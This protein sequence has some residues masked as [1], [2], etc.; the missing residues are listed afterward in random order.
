[1]LHYHCE[2]HSERERLDRVL[3]GSTTDCPLLSI[4]VK[5][6]ARESALKKS[7]ITARVVTLTRAA[8]SGF[9]ADR[10]YS[11]S[12]HQ[13]APSFSTDSPSETEKLLLDF[14][15]Q[16]RLGGEFTYRYASL[17]QPRL[18]LIRSTSEISFGQIY[19]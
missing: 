6:Y 18:A 4:V 11:V 10:V 16:Y 15:L 19:C 17:L 8:M 12:V 9:D 5:G 7:L 3:E 1:V 13:N 14:L 2:T